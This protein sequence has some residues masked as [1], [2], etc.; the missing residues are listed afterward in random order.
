MRIE[1][2]DNYTERVKDVCKGEIFESGNDYFIRTGT[3]Q[4]NRVVCVCLGD[5]SVHYVLESHRVKVCESATLL[6]SD[7]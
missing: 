2:K 6:I 3:E 1:V 4:G 7:E 5:G